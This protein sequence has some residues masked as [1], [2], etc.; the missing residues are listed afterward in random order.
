MTGSR[1]GRVVGTAE[2][3]ESAAQA[4]VEPVKIVQRLRD[5]Q[6]IRV[7]LRTTREWDRVR[8]IAYL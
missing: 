5:L 2:K 8:R 3:S 7:P 1:E 6:P 4:V